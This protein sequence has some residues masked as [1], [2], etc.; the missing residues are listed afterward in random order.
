MSSKENPQPPKGNKVWIFRFRRG[1]TNEE[2]IKSV[3]LEGPLR[4][5]EIIRRV[6]N[7]VGV[8]QSDVYKALN[9]LS[10]DYSKF[11][12]KNP[13]YKYI[14]RIDSHPFWKYD[15]TI[16]GDIAA[17]TLEL[18]EKEKLRLIERA[19]NHKYYDKERRSHDISP[20]IILKYLIDKRKQEEAIDCLSLISGFVRSESISLNIP[21]TILCP[22]LKQLI[23]HERNTIPKRYR[24]QDFIEYTEDPDPEITPELKRRFQKKR[25]GASAEPY[26]AALKETEDQY[27]STPETDKEELRGDDEDEQDPQ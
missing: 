26:K 20:F 4:S 8:Q 9:D 23:L 18:H 10:P 21:T 13:R 12:P 24:V 25:V 3:A 11:N 27:G 1:E 22:A 2:I 6:L 16:R 19:A 14:E 5:N 7:T 15:T 17:A